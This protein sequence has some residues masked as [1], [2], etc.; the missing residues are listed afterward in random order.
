MRRRL[1]AL[2]IGGI[3]GLVLAAGALA[4]AVTVGASALTVSS[5]TLT[6]GSC[7]LNTTAQG[8]DAYTQQDQAAK[9]TSASTTTIVDTATNKV[10]Y[11]WLQ[12]DLAQCSGLTGD[13]QVSSARLTLSI[14]ST[15]TNL[16]TRTLRLDPAAAAWTDSTVTWNNQP[17]VT[18]RTPAVT[19]SVNAAGFV[20]IDVTQDLAA[21]RST[22]TYGGS[23]NYGWRVS[24]L[25]SGS[26]TCC[27]TQIN[28][29]NNGTASVRP[30]LL[31]GYAG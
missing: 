25:G 11:T 21:W 7:T 3:A 20:Q 18:S 29:L 23:T 26:G 17:G 28:A 4:A 22:A 2:G 19:F 6:T 16:G 31:I 12:F 1:G 27:Q 5:K 30:S 10:N 8:S 15:Q 24:D 9:A 13:A 14:K